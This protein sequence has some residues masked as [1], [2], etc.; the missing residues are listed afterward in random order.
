MIM[1]VVTAHSMNLE[2]AK[3]PRVSTAGGGGGGGS[4]PRSSV[5]PRNR[6]CNGSGDSHLL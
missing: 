2:I 4:H 6:R 1:G 3:W 5:H